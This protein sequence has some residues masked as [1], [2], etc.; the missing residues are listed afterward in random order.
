MFNVM[1][2]I[3]NL[4]KKT[5]ILKVC[6]KSFYAKIDDIWNSSEKYYGRNI[7]PVDFFKNQQEKSGD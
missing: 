3:Q 1:E 5:I 7:N 6:A 4:K 2:K